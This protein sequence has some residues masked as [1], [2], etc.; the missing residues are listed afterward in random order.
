MNMSGKLLSSA[1]QVEIISNCANA[2]RTEI[3]HLITCPLHLGGMVFCV[4]EWLYCVVKLLGFL[5]I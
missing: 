3:S 1:E 5:T 4:A 2:G